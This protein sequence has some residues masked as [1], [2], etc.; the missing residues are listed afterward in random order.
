ME[1]DQI[2]KA[3]DTYCEELDTCLDI[4]PTDTKTLSILQGRKIAIE[5]LS[6]FKERILE[7]TRGEQSGESIDMTFN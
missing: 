4:D 6:K 5:L 2:L 7:T 1:K 3:I